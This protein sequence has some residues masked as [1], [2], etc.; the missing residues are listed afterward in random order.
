M[1]LCLM[2][3]FHRNRFAPGGPHIA[4]VQHRW[5]PTYPVAAMHHR[6]VL[7]YLM[8]RLVLTYVAVHCVGRGDRSP[9][10]SVGEHLHT[11]A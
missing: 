6:L 7:T 2:C 8:C 5:A 9:R 3:D 11:S 10:V 1:K 4:A